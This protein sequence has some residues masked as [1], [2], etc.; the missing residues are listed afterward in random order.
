M[1]KAGASF[2]Q[3][4]TA[5]FANDPKLRAGMERMAAAAAKIEGMPLRTITRVVFVPPGKPF[6]R[7]AALAP[8]AIADAPQPS[9]RSALGGLMRGRG[10]AQQPPPAAA[11]EATQSTFMTVTQEVR[12]ITVASLDASIFEPPANYRQVEIRR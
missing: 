1:A 4:L 12:S 11:Q 10:Q 9:L 7:A 5:A 3:G 6:D 2:A 8:A